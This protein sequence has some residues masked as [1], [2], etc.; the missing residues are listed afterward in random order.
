MSNSVEIQ[1][2]RCLEV[3]H[4]I[5]QKIDIQINSAYHEPT[6]AI[7]KAY[8]HT[9]ENHHAYVAIKTAIEDVKNTGDE[10]VD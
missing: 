10:K 1:C 5:Q 7:C 2:P 4:L 6:C 3:I 8:D 9:T